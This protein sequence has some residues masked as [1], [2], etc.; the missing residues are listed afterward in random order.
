MTTA[1]ESGKDAGGAGRE[2]LW[3]AVP[4]ISFAGIAMG[5]L[6]GGG[7]VLADAGLWG[8]VIASFFLA[9]LAY[10]KPRK[11]IV[12]LLA[13]MYALIIFVLPSEFELGLPMQVMFAASITAI[14]FRMEKKF[15]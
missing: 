2:R 1:T 11:D 15:S 5:V 6:A 7:T 12:S 13:P 8:C 10:L 14:A 3:L 4:A 9:I